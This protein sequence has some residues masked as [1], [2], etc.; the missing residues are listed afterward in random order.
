MQS[1]ALLFALLASVQL[2]S[3]GAFVSP[4]ATAGILSSPSADITTSRPFEA[5]ALDNPRGSTSLSYVLTPLA[6]A[7]ISTDGLAFGCVVLGCVN[8]FYYLQ[9]ISPWPIPFF[10][11]KY[12]GGREYYL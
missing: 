12:Y 3:V 4:K 6:E 9:I 11:T 5:K 10:I 7:P 2:A 1:K 8:I